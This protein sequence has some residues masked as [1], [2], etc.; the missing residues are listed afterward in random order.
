MGSPS[1]ANEK[2][3][4]STHN[5]KLAPL[6]VSLQN[7]AVLP[8]RCQRVSVQRELLGAQVGRAVTDNDFAIVLIRRVAERNAKLSANF[9]QHLHPFQDIVVDDGS[10]L[11]AIVCA[12]V[13]AMND[14]HL[15]QKGTLTTLS[16]AQ[17]KNLNLPLQML[18]LIQLSVYASTA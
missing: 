12:V 16:R 15:F 1:L 10:E 3:N 8:Q 2:L 11:Q 18:F 7:P 6:L 5:L 4:R 17:E 13:L 14:P 9:Y